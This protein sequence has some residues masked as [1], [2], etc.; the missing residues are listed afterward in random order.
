MP[1][2]RVTY[3]QY[4]PSVKALCV[5]LAE[6]EFVSLERTAE[7][8]ELVTNGQIAPSVGTI[9]NFIEESSEGAGAKH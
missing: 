1:G 5:L 6:A 7:I 4:D 2:T 3:A 8:L 9:R